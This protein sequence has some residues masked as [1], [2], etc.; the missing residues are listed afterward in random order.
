MSFM[1]KIIYFFLGAFVFIV[2]AFSSV[3]YARGGGG[4]S[5]SS[6]SGS[7]SSHS[8]TYVSGYSKNNGT[9]VAPHYRTKANSTKADN[10]ST[11]GNVNPYTDKVGTKVIED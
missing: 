9:H 1:K 3:T 5:H 7:G 8:H 6:R 2:S 4:H 11:K 10:F